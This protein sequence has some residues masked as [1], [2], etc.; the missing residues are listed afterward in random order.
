MKWA[1]V[2]DKE[3][4]PVKMDNVFNEF[5]PPAGVPWPKPPNTLNDFKSLR[6]GQQAS[7]NEPWAPFS[8]V[9]DWDYA[10][11][12]M[13]SGLSQRRIDSMLLLDLVSWM[14]STI[15]I[16]VTHRKSVKVCW[17]IFP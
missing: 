7:G 4:S 15:G 9:E 13:N 6:E 17:P 12:I 16:I 8:S 3:D 1:H 2:D 11:W 5:E 14:F 10:R